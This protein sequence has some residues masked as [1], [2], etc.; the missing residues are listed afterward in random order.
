MDLLV[1]HHWS[2]KTRSVWPTVR[3]KSSCR[4]KWTSEG[5]CKRAEPHS[6]WDACY[7]VIWD[8]IWDLA[9]IFKSIWPKS[10]DL[11][12]RFDLWFA[13]HALVRASVSW[14]DA[15]PFHLHVTTLKHLSS[16][17]AIWY[18]CGASGKVTTVLTEIND[19]L[20]PGLWL[21][22]TCMNSLTL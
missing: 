12:E 14:S 16:N 1:N 9:E 19:S 18:W 4:K 2:P 15:L 21:N 3:V 7:N 17:S 11:A 13:H 8:L 5:I 20:Q 10:C 22:L 6:P